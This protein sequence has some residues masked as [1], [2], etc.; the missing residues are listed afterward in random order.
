[1]DDASAP[2]SGVLD[3]AFIAEHTRGFEEL[4]ADVR[5]TSWQD[6]EAR[7]GLPM[8][9]LR[10]VAAAYAKSNAT[11]ITYGMG[12]TQHH[13]GTQN[14]QQ[15]ANLLL[16]RGNFGKPG[17]GICPL[18][19]HSNVQ[20]DRTVGITEKPGADMLRRIEET[21]GF[22]P[23]DTHGHDAVAAMQAISEGRSKVLICLGGN[24]AVAMPDPQR[25]FPG[26]RGLELSVHI[27]TKL[28]RS[29]LLTGMNKDDLAERGIEPGDE[30]L[31]ETAIGQ[32][33]ERQLA[34]VIAV[35]YSIARGS[36]ATYYPEAN[37]LVPL[38]YND[39]ASGTPSYKSIPV[40]IVRAH[41]E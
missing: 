39:Q 1:M 26:M 16:M 32:G 19:G 9:A 40:R 18:R 17:A 10:D 7:S 31:V 41:A 38:D 14:V 30:I 8:Q 6:I 27:G 11:I 20:G 33:P 28:N 29:H 34:K 22:K 21:F 15:V 23:P 35:A 24:L 25:C 37:C 2:G 3:H 5:A 36:V 12:L 4:A 13:Q